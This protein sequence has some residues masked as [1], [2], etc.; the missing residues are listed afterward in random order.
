[1][2][3]GTGRL[4]YCER[5]H[6]LRNRLSLK[7]DCTLKEINPDFASFKAIQFAGQA[8]TVFGDTATNSKW[9]IE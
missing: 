1:V 8:Q 6:P 7:S 5:G 3:D 2:G 9:R 4:F